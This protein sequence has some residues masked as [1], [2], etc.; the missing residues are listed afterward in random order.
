LNDNHTTDLAMAWLADKQRRTQTSLNDALSIA[1]FAGAD[2]REQLATLITELL[3]TKQPETLAWPEAVSVSRAWFKADQLDKA[4][5]WA[6]KAYGDAVGS[7]QAREQADERTLTRLS[8]LL[9][10]LGMVG[11]DK[12]YPAFAT[13]IA[14]LASD[15]KLET[16]V[17][18]ELD[19]MGYTLGTSEARDIVQAALVDSQGQ[20]RPVVAKILAWSHCRV[21]DSA[22]WK[23]FLDGKINDPGISGDAKALWL[24]ARSYAE[25]MTPNENWLPLRGKKFLDQALVASQTAP[26]RLV[27]VEELVNRYMGVKRPATAISFLDSVA[28][29]FDDSETVSLAVLREQLSASKARLEA[30]KEKA[31]KDAEL[32]RKLARLEFYRRRLAIWQGQ[33]NPQKA[34]RL[35]KVIA[36]LEAEIYQP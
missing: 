7:E 24:V 25:T 14:T 11:K 8:R 35:T 15:G 13:A 17:W 19:I 1:M 34:S 16:D 31:E 9:F 36:D 29:Q 28:N 33:N 32:E 18:Y 27:V 6:S 26:A 5:Q 23:E 4:R 2:N 12:G 22:G 21:G 10:D 20:P 30:K 3:T